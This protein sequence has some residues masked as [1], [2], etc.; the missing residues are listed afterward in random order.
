MSEIQAVYDMSNHR[1]LSLD[2][3]LWSFGHLL[4][5]I[6]VLRKSILFQHLHDFLVFLRGFPWRGRVGG[7]EKAGLLERLDLMVRD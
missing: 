6:V 1:D 5:T 2:Q 3:Q 7:V 4:F